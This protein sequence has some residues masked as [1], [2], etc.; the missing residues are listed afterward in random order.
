MSSFLI[1]RIIIFLSLLDLAVVEIPKIN[2]DF[3]KYSL[4][5]NSQSKVDI[6][7]FIDKDT[8]D[9]TA[10]FQ[11]AFDYANKNN[12]R[13]VY[14]P[15]GIYFL[16]MVH[17]YPGLEINGD[18]IGKT[19][20]KKI[21]R[22]RKFSRMFTIQ[23][24]IID[25]EYDT[26]YIHG[27]QF[28]GSR[29][30]QGEYKKHQLGQQHLIFLS[31]SNKSSYQLHSKIEN[32]LFH[33]GVGDA[34]S[35]YKNTVTS[36]INC[37]ARDVFRGGV[38]LTGGN[39]F[40]EIYNFKAWGETH[41]T[42]IDIEIDGRGLNGSLKADI[43]IENLWISG[44]FDISTGRGGSFLGNNIYCDGP[45]VRVAGGPIYIANSTFNCTYSKYCYINLPNSIVFDNC[46]FY[47]KNNNI[48]STGIQ[49]AFNI[50]WSKNKRKP[51]NRHLAFYSC[52]FQ[53]TDPAPN[54]PKYG[55]VHSPNHVKRNNSFILED[56]QFVGDFDADMLVRSGG[57]YQISKHS[58]NSHFLLHYQTSRQI[59]LTVDSDLTNKFT[60]NISLKEANK[61]TAIRLLSQNDHKVKNL[62]V[63]IEK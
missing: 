25:S 42:G 23:H 2:I 44:D 20:L 60:H 34:I 35:L 52:L 28:D 29:T 62:N 1:R 10:Y 4:Y 17:I 16:D 61:K 6:T 51:P 54:K 49:T 38:T 5:S 26:L 18:G 41:D 31:A 22:A 47:I 11:A 7:D 3:A 15:S 40:L 43:E 19:I 13:T 59:D 46:Q 8:S 32:C 37:E 14:I 57:N 56:C 53:L 27:L 12:I 33:D 24:Q 45:P 50:Y 58:T 55:I 21:P 9:H 30:Q 48:K 63:I 39:S 36:V